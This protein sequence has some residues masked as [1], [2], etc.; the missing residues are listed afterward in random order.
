MGNSHSSLG[1]PTAPGK[2]FLAVPSTAQEP[3][4]I[5]VRWKPP[6][7][8]GGSRITGY[9]VEHRRT[10]SPHWVKATPSK[11]QQNQLTLGGLEPGWRY[12][13][14]VKAANSL[15][16]STPSVVSDPVTITVHRTAV[17]APVF[18]RDIEDRV[19][20]ENDQVKF[21][22][23]F[24]GMPA[25]KISWYKDGFELFSNRRQRVSTDNGVSILYIHQA[26]YSDE[27][28]IKCSA[29]N[30]AGHAVTKAKLRLEA[31]PMVRLPQ[32]YE[33]GLLL[34]QNEPMRLK[35]SVSGRPLPQITWLHD[36]KEIRGGERY[37]VIHTDKF[38]ALKLPAVKRS[39]RGCYQIHAVNPIGEYTASF[40][41][42]VTDRPSPPGKIQVSK[43]SGKSVMLT[44]KPPEDDG[45][46][47]IG[48]Y[49]VE[50]NRVGWDMWLKATTS[51]QLTTT[52]DD[53]LEGSEYRFRVKAENPYGISLPSDVSEPIFLPDIKRGIY[54]PIVTASL[55]SE[56]EEKLVKF[57]ETE[58]LEHF[59]RNKSKSPDPFLKPRKLSVDE[60]SPPVPKRRKKKP[61]T[62][63]ISMTSTG[64]SESL[65]STSQDI[66]FD[67]WQQPIEQKDHWGLTP[68]SKAEN[69]R[70]SPNH[71]PN[72][73]QITM[74]YKTKGNSSN[75]LV[76]D[77][78]RATAPPISISS[79]ELGADVEE[80]E[81]YLRNSFSSSELLYER[82]LHRF[83]EYKDNENRS[84]EAH[85]IAVYTMDRKNSLLKPPVNC[86]RS[87]EDVEER[88]I[89]SDS[90]SIQS[91]IEVS[92]VSKSDSFLSLASNS[93]EDD[94]AKPSV[95]FSGSK[96]QLVSKSEEYLNKYQS[97]SSSAESESDDDQMRFGSGK[98][99]LDHL[100]SS[101]F[102]S[103]IFDDDYLSDHKSDRSVSSAKEADRAEMI[104][105]DSLNS[106]SISSG[107]GDVSQLDKECGEMEKVWR[108]D[109]ITRTVVDHLD[110]ADRL[111][112]SETEEYRLRDFIPKHVLIPN[113]F[114]KEPTG[115]S[116][117]ESPCR[118]K[119]ELSQNK[120]EI[121]PP[122]I[123]KR[124]ET[125]DNPVALPVITITEVNN[126]Y[127][128][129]SILKKI[130][131]PSFAGK[132][133]SFFKRNNVKSDIFDN[134]KKS[135]EREYVK[136]RELDQ[137][138]IRTSRVH[139]EPKLMIVQHY[140]SIIEEYNSGKKPASKTYLDFDQLKMAAVEDV[141]PIIDLTPEVPVDSE[142]DEAD[143]L[144]WLMKDEQN[145][146]P[147]ENE[148]NVADAGLAFMEAPPTDMGFPYLKVFGNLS[149]MLFGY[150]LYM[151]KDER[152]SVPVFGFLIFRFFKTQIW[153]RI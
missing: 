70:T 132:T 117:R 106:E 79:P 54:T 102:F 19:A 18:V 28:E 59:G 46:C 55:L 142:Q 71:L 109:F 7:Y 119:I 72:P 5:T 121:V 141:D 113:P 73:H 90:G 1:P 42:T 153:D 77:F 140:G 49:I 60:V 81:E 76:F 12:Q 148:L 36:G 62:D 125:A 128:P 37:E 98:R 91:V 47:K 61:L 38:A 100:T 115:G 94:G 120:E 124:E 150:W 50:Y 151:C 4:V 29:T 139:E 95:S 104:S 101:A 114:Y 144:K 99:A 31:P 152:L 64:T 32:D 11:V 35:V 25:P 107:G 44:W 97:N 146:L 133:G 149:L 75:S 68:R 87:V 24:E 136:K 13:F 39:D 127:S 57:Q 43:I 147:S 21:E 66:S 69:G 14:R 40:L 130:I 16:Q 135:P 123:P 52:L 137:T 51:R 83:N 34:E 112:W 82:N 126:E 3:D 86:R 78:D 134:V 27:G 103:T 8:D 96:S 93:T 26:E 2:P 89:V 9:L 48:S 122:E 129:K 143:D 23:E 116:P 88:S 108:T 63:T 110:D 17:V 30:K 6:T 105:Q 33:E 85:K 118:L 15:G 58:M 131:V 67:S 45:G 10:T 56:D 22:V 80:F 84:S 74:N 41:V 138:D 111:K 20:L 65:S 92:K 53:L 145:L